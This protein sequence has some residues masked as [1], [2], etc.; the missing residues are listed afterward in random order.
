MSSGN[1]KKYLSIYLCVCVCVSI[2]HL[3]TYMNFKIL[4]VYYLIIHHSVQNYLS[5][6]KIEHFNNI[7]IGLHLP[8][9]LRP[10]GFILQ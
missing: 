5:S 3:S 9:M 10:S 7:T 4:P 1:L 6:N 8:L 2:Y